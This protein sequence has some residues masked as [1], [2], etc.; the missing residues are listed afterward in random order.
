M[1][2]LMTRSKS[3]ATIVFLAALRLQRAINIDRSASDMAKGPVNF[4]QR[5]VSGGYYRNTKSLHTKLDLEFL[6]AIIT[7]GDGEKVFIGESR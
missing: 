6:M 2:K 1:K 4:T 3:C 7:G 5:I